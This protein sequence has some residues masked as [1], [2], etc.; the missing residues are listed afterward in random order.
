MGRLFPRYERHTD[1]PV[2]E[3]SCASC[4]IFTE[5][6]PMVLFDKPCNCP[7]CAT[8]APR[9]M[10]TAPGRASMSSAMK[11]AH[12][13]NERSADNP[14]RTGHGPGCGCC[15]GGGKKISSG[16]LHRPDGS[17]SFPKKRPWMIS[18]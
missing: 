2:S 9:V 16:T 3:Y 8:P 6:A 7:K 12:E 13:T 10:L 5:I 11:G 18:H 4:G 1:M 15:G 14:K 17:K